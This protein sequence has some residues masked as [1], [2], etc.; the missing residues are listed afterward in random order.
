MVKRLSDDKIKIIISKYKELK[1]NNKLY[2]QDYEL[3]EIR[4][5]FQEKFG[6]DVLKSKNDNELLEFLFF[7]TGNRNSAA[8]YME[9][10]MATKAKWFFGPYGIN[11]APIRKVKTGEWKKG[12][13]NI[14]QNEALS[15]AI[16]IKEELINVSKI[17]QDIKY[18]K[19]EY[20]VLTDAFKK[21]QN[22][23]VLSKSYNYCRYYLF[24]LYPDIL[25]S[26]I[27]IKNPI[28]IPIIKKTKDYLEIPQDSQ[29]EPLVAEEQIFYNF[30]EFSVDDIFHVI[31]NILDENDWFPQDYNP[32]ISVNE[33]YELIN[34]KEIFDINSLKLIKRLYDIGGVATCKQLSEK[35]GWQPQSYNSFAVHLAKRIHKKTN[36][37][38]L[39]KNNDNAKWWTILFL[40]KYTD[41]KEEGVYVWKLRQELKQAIEKVDLS[42]IPLMEDKNLELNYWWIN[43]SPELFEF[44]KMKENQEEFYTFVNGKGNKRQIPRNFADAKVGDKFIGYDATPIASIVALGEITKRDN[45]ALYFKKIK[46]LEN[47]ISDSTIKKYEALSKMERNSNTQKNRQGSLFKLSKQEYDFIM[48][49]IDASNSNGDAKMK[50]PLNQILYGP[51]GTG[52]T[53]NTII[54]AMEI[55]K[56]DIIKWK[57]RNDH[58]KGINDYDVLKEEFNY[59][60]SQ[61]QIEFV[62][63]HQSYSYEEFVEGIKPYIPK[64]GENNAQDIKYIGNDGIFKKM[65]LNSKGTVKNN[66]DEVYEKF[67]NDVN[68]YCDENDAPFILKTSKDKDFGIRINGNNNLTLY[69]GKS[70]QP[71]GTLTKEN[72]E[73]VSDWHY[74]ARPIINYFESHYNY[75]ESFV[76]NNSPKVL[77]IDEI[78][79]GNISKIFGELITLIEDDKRENITVTLPYSQK[80]FTVPKNLYIIGT[81]NT[82]DRSIA[83]VDIAL[84]RRFRFVEMMPKPELLIDKNDN[85]EITVRNSKNDKTELYKINLQVLLK[86]LNERISYLLDPDHQIGHS[87]FLNLLKDENGNKKD[88]ILESDLKD[89]FKYE[90][91][92]LLNEYFYD[93]WDKLRDVLIRADYKELGLSDKD[94]RDIY[95][96][97]LIKKSKKQTLFCSSVE[98]TYEFNHSLFDNT[99]DDKDIFKIAIALIGKDIIENGDNELK[100]QFKSVPA[101]ETNVSEEVSSNI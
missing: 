37:N 23:V 76:Y 98:E 4:K 3:V 20:S 9:Y 52:K 75:S 22:D 91:L 35:Y 70:L 40:G 54:K 65:C 97:S 50:Q 21:L 68:E 19:I 2:S 30:K 16:K 62:T 13:E 71:N 15:I 49:L 29:E 87:Y 66:F 84:R 28:N 14:N 51:P 25:S 38:V 17:I 41:N 6:I 12:N 81:M 18:R 32:N 74:Y 33:W 95:K 92:P 31:E 96:Y 101:S 78:N 10:K 93:D 89:V 47:P 7:N 58:S 63:F 72:L 100:N 5:S 67:V 43:A 80:Q 55:I 46:S 94:N 48:K 85:Y 53:Y 1:S 73:A 57:D 60:K 42:S 79:R 44:S 90:I 24:N 77:I 27:N 34:N 61:G 82:A 64:W 86:T 83:S 59:Y 26:V 36:C 56:P 88:Y 99:E 8:Y 45:N 11:E 69:M 39:M